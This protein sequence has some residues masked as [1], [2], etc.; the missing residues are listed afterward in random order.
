[1]KS[2]VTVFL[3]EYFMGDKI[4]KSEMGGTYGAYGEWER[5]AQGSGGKI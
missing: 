2:L 1:M 3:I 4:E 5:G